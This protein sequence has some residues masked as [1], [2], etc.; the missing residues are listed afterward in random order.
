MRDP[1]VEGVT[2][3]EVK[4]TPDLRFADVY[5]SRLGGDAE[6]KEAV[7]GLEAAAGFLRHELAPRIDLRFVPELRF[8]L[9]RSWEQGA[10]IEALLEEIATEQPPVEQPEEP[11]EE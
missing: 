10:R 6:R 9:D 3:T 7:Q 2:I 4:V 11:E 5:V 8:H 1:R